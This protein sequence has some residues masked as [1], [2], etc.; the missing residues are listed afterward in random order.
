MTACAKQIA[1]QRKDNQAGFSLLESL[2]AV[3]LIAAAFLPL[4]ALQG[5]LAR[6]VFAAERA[7]TSV[8]DMTSALSYLRTVNPAKQPEGTEPLGDA[9]LTWNAQPV[10]EE[11][12]ALD[13][14]GAPGRFML[15]LY[16]VNAAITYSDG[17]RAEFTVRSMGWR[18]TAPFAESFE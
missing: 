17:R 1:A 15:R 3:A 10:S 5:Q 7:E 11:R 18:P 14:S 12:P 8:K 4:L 16:E 6:T 9:V 2:V 13:Q